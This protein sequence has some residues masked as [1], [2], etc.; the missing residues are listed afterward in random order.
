[1]KWLIV[2]ET[3]FLVLVLPVFGQN[4]TNITT[5]QPPPFNGKQVSF[6]S[7][8][9]RLQL[10]SHNHTLNGSFLSA[11]HEGAA[12][13]NLGLYPASFGPDSFNTFTLNE[14]KFVCSYEN[15]TETACPPGFFPNNTLIGNPGLLTWDLPLGDSASNATI[16]YVPQV[17]T[18]V[19]RGV[20]SNFAFTVISF[21]TDE[22]WDPSAP[23]A[24]DKDGYMNLLDNVNNEAPFGDSKAYYRWYV[25]PVWF[26]DY[27]WLHLVWAY[28]SAEPNFPGCDKVDVKRVWA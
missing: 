15:G 2:L 11:V 16:E 23:V 12:L 18:L 1:M 13:E 17:M 24:F 5:P 22:G 3:F 9:F 28:G 26:T 21:Y 19:P 8:P 4:G 10:Q 20:S 25:C 6:L 27:P 7:A 14:T